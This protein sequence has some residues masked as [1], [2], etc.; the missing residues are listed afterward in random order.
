MSPRRLVSA[1]AAMAWLCL[2]PPVRSQ[3]KDPFFSGP[4]F[5]LEGLLQRVGVIAD[6]RLATAVERRGIDFSPSAADYEKLKQA[7][8]SEALLKIVA[9]K[10]PPPKSAPPKPA[11]AP[12]A[13]ARAGRL[14][15]QCVPAECEVSLDGK[16]QGS[17]TQGA[18][19]F[20]GLP[21]GEHVVDFRKEGFEGQQ[22]SLVMTA[23]ASTAQTITLKPTGAT[24]ARAGKILLDKMIEKLGGPALRRAATLTASG[25]ASLFQAAGQR[26][27]WQVTARLRLPSLALL[28]IT[29]AGIRWWTSLN[30]DDSKAGGSRQMAGKPVALEMEKLV[31]LYRDY[32]P[33]M[34]VERLRGTAVSALDLTP[35]PSGEYRVK[36]SA[37]DGSLQFTLGADATLHRVVYESASGL[38]SGLEVLYTEYAAIGGAWY[39]KSM[40]IKFSD[41]EQHGLELRFSEVA[42]VDKLP[43]KEFHR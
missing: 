9:A 20:R 3:E 10:A 31:R 24:R 28:E 12:A 40:A 42:F 7:G 27:E 23:G 39:P 11:P 6:K 25:S 33:A 32:Q 43:D 30:A 34:L 5:S 15:F 29:G 16:P 13:P 41:K 35:Q 19:E 37:S 2:A 21:A 4:P 22:F 17:T 38:G 8:A 18:I 26:T 1:L 14:S 36:S